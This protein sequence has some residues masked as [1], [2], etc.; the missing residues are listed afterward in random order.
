VLTIIGPSELVAGQTEGVD[1]EIVETRPGAAKHEPQL[2]VNS[3]TLSALRRTGNGRWVT[4]Y[5]LPNEKYPQV[6]L[7]AAYDAE[8]KQLAELR[9]QL[10]GAP[11]VVVQSEPRVL[12]EVRNGVRKFGPIRTDDKGRAELRIIVPPGLNEVATFATDAFGNVSESSLP[13][14]LPRFS[15]FFPVCA[16][17]EQAVYVLTTD[18]HGAPQLDAEFRVHANGLH[19]DPPTTQA[20]GLYRFA[21]RPEQ[22]NTVETQVSV[23]V[24]AA[25][26]TRTCVAKLLPSPTPPAAADSGRKQ[27]QAADSTP[28]VHFIGGLLLGGSTNLGK[29]NGF[30][31]GLRGAYPF[32]QTRA[33]LRLEVEAAYLRSTNTT[34]TEDGRALKLALDALPLAA[35]LRYVLPVGAWEPNLALG[36]GVTLSQVVAGGSDSRAVAR[37][38]P[39]L[40]G[41][42][43]GLGLALGTGT[44][45]VEAGYWYSNLDSAGITGNVH[46]LRAGLGYMLHL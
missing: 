9:M 17:A 3:G 39:V 22:L 7:V 45:Q 32:S 4:T 35:N 13:L 31:G 29:L 37:A 30:W 2:Y 43:L 46:G 11:L 25:S 6:I 28:P 1:L 20:P 16:A 26:E 44:V 14:H 15:R 33:G 19:I 8:H 41:G 5:T 21:F 40:F 10:L 36:V 42:A 34:T 27:S 18:L 24:S 12:L 38:T 23:S